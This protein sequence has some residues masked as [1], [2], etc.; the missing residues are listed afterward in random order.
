[1]A[2]KSIS[3]KR[4]ERQQQEN[5]A[6]NRVFLV[7]LLGLAAEC[8][9]FFVYRGYVVGTVSAMLAWRNVLRYG[10]V[11]GL[12]L[13]IAG[14]ALAVMSYKKGDRKKGAIFCWAAGEGA[15]FAV[16]GWI[17]STS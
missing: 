2:K 14:A 15:F 12:V 17:M 5:Q 9:L 16:S 1:M 7:F 10:A 6:L 13:L 8:Y 11:I 4:T 3:Q